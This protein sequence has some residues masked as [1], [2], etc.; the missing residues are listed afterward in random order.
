[1]AVAESSTKG[2]M[3]CRSTFLSFKCSHSTATLSSIL[4]PWPLATVA[5]LWSCRF[6]ILDEPFGRTIRFGNQSITRECI[7]NES[8]VMNSSAR[9]RY[10][11]IFYRINHCLYFIQHRGLSISKSCRSL[12]WR[13]FDPHST[14]TR[15]RAVVDIHLYIVLFSLTLSPWT[16]VKR[17]TFCLSCSWSWWRLRRTMRE[18]HCGCSG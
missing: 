2:L 9:A 14:T 12:R 18:V 7:S 8:I 10:S 3:G 17:S 6:E 1:M 13:H 4:W 15:L 16:F 5:A 11:V